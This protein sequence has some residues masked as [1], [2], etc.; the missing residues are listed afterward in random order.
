M[1]IGYARVST[2]QQNLENQTALLKEEGCEQIYTEVISGGRSKHSRLENEVIPCL[3]SGDTLVVTKFCRLGRSTGHLLEIL[4]VLNER[5]VKLKSIQENIDPE[6][7]MGKFFFTVMAF[8]VDWERQWIRERIKSALGV[9]KKKHGRL[10]RRKG[11]TN[12]QT[13]KNRR[14]AYVLRKHEGYKLDEIVE[15]MNCS[16]T[17][18]KR[19]IWEEQNRIKSKNN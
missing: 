5:G 14:M 15:Y 4:E 9:I 3:R 11:S 19:W 6:T 8:M 7:P 1:K 2:A 10:G 13:Q 17:S 18:V 12:P 16:K